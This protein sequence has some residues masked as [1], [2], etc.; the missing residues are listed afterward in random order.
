MGQTIIY[1]KKVLIKVSTIAAGQKFNPLFSF[2]HMISTFS[3]KIL[4]IILTY[5]FR[6]LIQGIKVTQIF[7]TG[8]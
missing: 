3:I 1:E 6:C 2:V 7:S 4:E 5:F 8:S